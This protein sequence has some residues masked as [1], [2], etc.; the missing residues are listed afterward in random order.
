MKRTEWT[1]EYTAS[2]L[3]EAAQVKRDHRKAR[4]EWWESKRSEVMSEVKD[5]GLEVSESLAMDYSKTSPGVGPQ[6]M[7]RNDLQR[8]LTECY[9]K[10]KEHAEAMRQYEG[11][12]QVFAA[13]PESRLSLQYDDWLYFFGE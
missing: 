2:K 6:V 7:V 4:L 9:G 12:R 5:S 11:W 8:K 13:N 1:F 3:S 10:I